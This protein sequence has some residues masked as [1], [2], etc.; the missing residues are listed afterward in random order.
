MLAPSRTFGAL[1]MCFLL[2]TERNPSLQFL[3]LSLISGS[4]PPPKCPPPL[5]GVI[6]S[7][8][9]ISASYHLLTNKPNKPILVSNFLLRNVTILLLVKIVLLFTKSLCKIHRAMGS[10]TKMSKTKMDP[11]YSK[12]L[13]AE[14]VGLFQMIPQMLVLP[15]PP[16][17]LL[18][19]EG[20]QSPTEWYSGGALGDTY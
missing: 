3:E 20:H 9:L 18:L 16:I 8:L 5:P 11:T 7:L 6:L 14:M 1:Y 19:L 15:L 10:V 12:F 17:Y 4:L 13:S 2:H